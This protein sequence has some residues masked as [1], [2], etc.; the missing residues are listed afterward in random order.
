MSIKDSRKPLPNGYILR[1]ND[2]TEHLEITIKELIGSGGSCLVYKGIHGITINGKQEEVSVII[3]ELYPIVLNI[4]RA[5]DQNLVITDT[6]IFEAYKEHFGKGQAENVEYYEYYRDQSLPPI[7]FF[8]AV[9]NTVYAVSSASKGRVLSDINKESLSMNQVASIMESI[10]TAIRRIHIKEKLYLDCKPDNFFYYGADNDLQTKVYLFDFDTVISIEDI[11]KENNVF[12]T[13]SAGWVPPEQELVRDNSTGSVY[14]RSQTRIGYHTD[15]YSVGCVFFWLLVDRK[16]SLEDIRKIQNGS[17]DWEKESRICDGVEIEVIKTVQDICE[18]LLQDDVDKRSEKFRNYISISC[19]RDQFRNLYGLTVGNNVHFVPIFE[20]IKN[21]EKNVLDDVSKIKDDME[22]THSEIENVKKIIEK[23][24]NKRAVEGVPTKIII[25]AVICIILL[26]CIILY[27]YSTKMKSTNTVVYV[28]QYVDSSMV[29]E[30]LEDHILLK[31]ENANHQYEVGLENWRRLDYLRAERDLI[32]SCEIIGEENAQSDIELAKIN[33]SIGCLYLD[34]GR[35]ADAYDYLNSAYVSFRDIFGADSVACRAT[36]ASIA[37]YYYNIGNLDEALVETQLILDN[38][39]ENS[40]RVIITYTNHIRAMIYDAQG[41]YDEALKIYSEVLGLYGDILED[42]Q[43]SEQLADYVNS[44]ELTQTDKDNYTNAIKWIM[45][46]YNNIAN[47]NI[48]KGDYDSAVVAA[49]KGIDMGIANVYIGKRNITTSKLYMNLAIAQ[50]ALGE[51]GK[52]IDNIDLAMRIQRNIFDFKDIYPG[53]VE[54]YDAYADLLM[55]K[56][57]E[58]DAKEYY[59]N[60]VELSIASFGENSP[61]TADALVALGKYFINSD[62]PVS[63]EY[64]KRAIEI[65]KNIL[66]ANHPITAQ[67]YYYLAE[68]QQAEGQI[69]ESNESFSEAERINS[70]CGVEN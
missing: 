50:G 24:N 16:P 47:V 20:A 39:N 17:F 26:I 11:R 49:N 14:Y 41:K 37:L 6:D 69:Q 30:N 22:N 67:F 28:E 61:Y 42:G 3:K 45:I 65:R 57:N 33:N 19:I 36:M 60:A 29:E 38:S 63:I 43:L 56:G 58:L 23:S 59:E 13:A 15:I 5:L 1:I 31:L 62:A 25:G 2:G 70:I 66:S 46:T 7:F 18:S 9:N 8:G 34:M 64:F 68:A 32:A 53:L 48:H 55:V 4:E 54:I 35:Y 10:C 44:S 27:V 52:A 40:E 21:M 12:C 51:C